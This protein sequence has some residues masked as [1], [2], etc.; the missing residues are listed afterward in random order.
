M[1]N[2]NHFTLIGTHLVATTKPNP[3]PGHSINVRILH[4][5]G[6]HIHIVKRSK[7]EE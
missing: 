5:T 7:Q 1:D 4:V 3:F 2:L 6:Q